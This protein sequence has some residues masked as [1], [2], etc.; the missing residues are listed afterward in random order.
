MSPTDDLPYAHGGPPLSG[1][2]RRSPEDFFVDED[3][4]FAPDGSGE[5]AFVRVEKRGANT[6]WVGRELARFAG[7]DE[8]AVGYAGMKDRH[9][10]TRQTFSIHLPGRS[11][12][13]WAAL[14]HDEFRVLSAARHSRKLKIGALRGNVFRIVA[15]DVSGD[16]GLLAD[17]VEA[18]RRHGVP[19]YF[20][21]QRFGRGGD[22]VE[23][24]RRLF[25]G[26]RVRRHERGMLLSAARS[27]LFNEVLAA[28]VRNGSW[29]L[30]HDGDVWML[31]GS[32]S[33][34]GP[35]PVDDD[36]RQRIASGDIAPTG[37][38]F[39]E[40]VLRSTGEVAA[41]EQTVAAEH[42]DLIRGL[43]SNGL[44]QE[45]RALVLRAG[46]FDA[47]WLDE[48]SLAM[49]FDLRKG[50]YATVIIREIVNAL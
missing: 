1:A 29:N 43:A 11:D 22:N 10:V 3:L 31:D 41:F 33:I 16:R 26:S 19:N 13:D 34:F 24:A 21:E 7:A 27:F 40:G 6:D 2:L 49:R 17:R 48:R 39:G 32:Q 28:R 37:P 46:E 14:Q 38:L 20:G 23:N 15:R 4:G 30:A 47:E 50:S 44:R 42:E 9:A 12:P 8:R 35:Q 5:H 25:A 36:I 18:M 45:R